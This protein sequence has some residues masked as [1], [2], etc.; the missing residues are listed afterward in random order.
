MKTINCFVPYADAAQVQ[1]TVNALRQSEL[2]TKIFLL[3][4]SD[5]AQPLD[6][7]ELLHIDTITS[8]ATMKKIAAAADAGNN[9]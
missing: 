7:C 6:G 9:D 8:S 4:T 1:A 2:V 5:D 3:A